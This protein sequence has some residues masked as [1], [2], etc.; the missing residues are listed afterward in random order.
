MFCPGTEDQ[1]IFPIP[2]ADGHRIA[3]DGI[4]PCGAIRR[5]DEPNLVVHRSADGREFVEDAEAIFNKTVPATAAINQGLDIVADAFVVSLIIAFV[6]GAQWWEFYKTGATM[7][8]SHRQ[9][10]EEKARFLVLKGTLGVKSGG[11]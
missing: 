8:G 9:E 1:R 5:A 4:C 6:Q 2:D 11:T 3:E 10:A 7:W